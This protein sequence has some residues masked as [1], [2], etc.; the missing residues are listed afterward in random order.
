MEFLLSLVGGAVVLLFCWGVFGKAVFA[1]TVE[2]RLEAS[3]IP[4]R[5]VEDTL[6]WKAYHSAL[7][8]CQRGGMTSSDTANAL[9]QEAITVSKK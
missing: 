4:P 6:G 2:R 7:G 5:W 3:G 9:L 1:K 8:V